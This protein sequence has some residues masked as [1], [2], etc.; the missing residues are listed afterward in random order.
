MKIAGATV[1]LTG[2]AGGIGQVLARRLTDAGADLVVTSRDSDKLRSLAADLG[3]RCVPADLADPQDV[4]DLVERCGDVDI[5]VANAG[6]PASGDLFEYTPEQ[7]DRALTVNLSSAVMLAR[8]LAPAMVRAKKGHLAF[9]GSVAGMLTTPSSSLYSAAKFGLRGFVH[10]LRQDLHSAG[11]GVSLIQ[12]GVVG[13]AGMFAKTG[14]T[15]P[16]G[17]RTVTAGQVADAMIKAIE[18]NRAE[19]TVAPPEL[20]ILCALA[21]QFPGAAAWIQRQQPPDNTT[22]RIVEAQRA[23]R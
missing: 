9:V 12:P 7:V 22:Q 19:I 1:L 16:K 15:P 21:L 11:V 13:D 18:R 5:L 10:A 6:K 3:A 4:A 17:M 20:R 23:D 2:A 8:L 14:I